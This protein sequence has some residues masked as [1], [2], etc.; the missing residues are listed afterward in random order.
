MRS[1]REKLTF[2]NVMS[3]IAV[4]IALGGVGYAA[5]RLPKNSVGPKQIRN[6]AVNEAKLSASAKAALTGAKGDQGPL[7]PTGPRGSRGPAGPGATSFATTLS[8]GTTLAT[9]ATTSTGLTV[10]GSCLTGPSTVVLR[11]KT[12]SGANNIQ[13]S[14]TENFATTVS[15]QD[16][17]NSPGAVQTADT[18]N[19]D[20]DV[21][22]RDKTIGP[23]ARLDI[24][25]HFGAPCTYWGMITPSA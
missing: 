18:N 7:G 25:G 16:A 4:F 23:F 19:A 15:V 10:Q 17:D 3:V 8:Q 9:L 12:T 1:V 11:I 6:G 22:A 21:V 5:S 2:A 14:G 13:V 24:H 20:F